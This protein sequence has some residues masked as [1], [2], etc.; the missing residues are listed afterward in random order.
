MDIPILLSASFGE[1]RPN[2]F[3][4]GIDIK[5]QGTEGK[6]I[7]AVADGYVS[8]IGVSPWG[9]GNVLYIDH[10]EGETTTVYAH[11]QRFAPEIANYVKKKQYENER[12]NIDITV[13][14]EIFPV[15]KG[16][17]VAYS[18]N[19]GSSGG[20][21]LHFEIRERDT[22]RPTDA[23]LPYLSNIKDTKPPVVKGVAIRAVDGKG[24]VMGKGGITE[25][26]L[27]ADKNGRKSISQ[28]IEAWGEIG[29]EIKADDVMDN[30][31]NVYG[32]KDITLTVDGDTIFR[33]Y[34]DG[35]LFDE[36]R[37]INA[38][39]DYER[40]K[41][42]EGFYVRSYILP[43]NK[44]PFIRAKKRGIINIDEERAYKL[45][46]I[47]KDAF[48]NTTKLP[49]VIN[50]KAQKIPETDTTGTERFQW[51]SENRFGA[52]GVRL[53]VPKGAL[54][55]DIDFSYSAIPSDSSAIAGTH[56]IHRNTVPLHK[57][58]TLSIRIN[59]DNL[60]DK[61]KYG[62]VSVSNGKKSWVG[63]EYDD[64]WMRADIKDFGTYSV[65]TDTVPPV[66]KPLSKETWKEKKR[67]QFVLTDNLSGVSTY[68]GEID[69]Q[70]VLFEMNSHSVITYNIDPKRIEKGTNH[71]LRLVV[72]DDAGNESEYN[73]EFFY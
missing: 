15:K 65:A 14:P 39:V 62:I 4:S 55:D 36:T 60:E 58:A 42:R 22:Q 70:F 44:L 51:K 1:L 52:K 5:T 53:T 29:L 64:G 30:T 31:Q 69:G 35:Y 33:S 57:A 8:R 9:Y 41:Q 47:L 3:H 24:A 59:K 32:I 13:E 61:S 26:K 18:G 49:F 48:G 17:I 72:K 56:R 66:V 38:S 20:P 11:L 6:A 28:K 10:P 16:D 45:E 37:Y 23:I 68:R 2:H 67:F 73:Y 40:W 71:E 43:G 21:H 19:T 7:R 54:Y 46:Y 27:A 12:F 50:G 25:L 63:G 34:T